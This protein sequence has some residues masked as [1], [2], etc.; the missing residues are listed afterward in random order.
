MRHGASGAERGRLDRDLG[1]ISSVACCGPNGG[2]RG[3]ALRRPM[4]ANRA[5]KQPSET[6]LG[7]AE[8]EPQR[9]VDRWQHRS[10]RPGGYD[11]RGRFRAGQVHI[12]T[13]EWSRVL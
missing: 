5:I 10:A 11:L 2:F 7:V 1:S 6:K 4:R 12:E 9:H 3:V 13:A 8:N